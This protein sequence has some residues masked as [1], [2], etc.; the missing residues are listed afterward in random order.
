MS[1]ENPMNNMSSEAE[2]MKERE[3]TEKDAQFRANNENLNKW[4]MDLPAPAAKA[5]LLFFGGKDKTTA[6][7]I[8]H[9]DANREN[10]L[11]DWEKELAKSGLTIEDVR[12]EFHKHD[13]L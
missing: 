12:K 13:S 4:Y 3:A 8:M 10:E 1:M 5:F 9:E 7:D 2:I 6:M 11:R